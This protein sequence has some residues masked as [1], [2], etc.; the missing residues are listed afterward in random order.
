MTGNHNSINGSSDCDCWWSSW[1]S[2]CE[3]INVLKRNS[4]AS[5]RLNDT[6]SLLSVELNF[7]YTY[8]GS[9]LI[10]I[11]W[12]ILD[13]QLWNLQHFLKSYHRR[14]NLQITIDI[15][16]K[17]CWVKEPF[18]FSDVW[19]FILCNSVNYYH[20]NQFFFRWNYVL[21]DLQ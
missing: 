3:C 21:I 8:D 13:I 19:S 9:W 17:W 2:K 15:T 5:F 1:L 4:C 6:N 18:L 12:F 16:L 14:Y 11:H 10:S 7:K 20:E